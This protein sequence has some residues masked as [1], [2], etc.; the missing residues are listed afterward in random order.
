M[1]Q[2][3]LG[4]RELRA[5]ATSTRL[6]KLRVVRDREGVKL[7]AHGVL[8]AIE[9][10]RL[11]ETPSPWL[12][13]AAA[14]WLPERPGPPEAVA[15][16]GYGGG[17]LA[18]LLRGADPR[19]RLTGVEPDEAVRHLAREHLGALGPGVRLIAG[20]LGG[21]ARAARFDAILDDIYAPA[22]GHL[23]RPE[24]LEV[25][26][27]LARRRLRP[28]GVYAVSLRSPGGKVERAAVAAVRR[29]F[30]HVRVVY[31]GEWAHRIV[32]GSEAPLRPGALGRALR[33]LFHSP[34]AT[35]AALGLGPV[36]ALP[37]R[38]NPG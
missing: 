29:S 21:G 9:A 38:G 20:P 18:R 19:L 7:I 1:G 4:P 24:G 32:V 23:S 3:P 11:E 26:P 27:G 5:T 14:L 37:G 6:G 35:P 34:A 30:R 15:L 12:A 33:R 28:G 36:R 16:L 31:T 25:L 17:T 22:D 8:Y 13:L 2:K 10:R